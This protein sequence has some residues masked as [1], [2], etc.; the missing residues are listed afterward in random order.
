MCPATE[1][2]AFVVPGREVVSMPEYLRLARQVAQL[3]HELVAAGSGVDVLRAVALT[4]VVAVE[5]ADHA[6][7][8]RVS[9]GHLATL[10]ATGEVPLRA[11]LLQSELGEGP[12]LDEV[13]D[14]G[15]L[16]AD[17]LRADGR[18]PGFARRAVAEH[19]I[20]SVLSFRMFSEEA[21]PP[22]GLNLYATAP[23]AFDDAAVMTGLVLATHGALGVTSLARKLRGDHLER[24]LES[25]R[26]IGVAIGIL[27]A[28]HLVSQAEAFDLLRVASQH[29]HR[30][31]ADIALDVI[32]TGILEYPGPRKHHNRSFHE[33]V[34]RAP[35]S[36]GSKRSRKVL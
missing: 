7:I 21:G 25:N 26:S 31:L 20:L 11:D 18:W 14:C 29:T 27:M 16:R 15:E 6:S 2:R 30:K 28:R 10:A 9:G 36:T 22:T 24:A 34:V 5:G 8:T 1:R 12:C 23:G 4:A 32:D 19:G 17:D 13:G 3:G 33:T 35:S